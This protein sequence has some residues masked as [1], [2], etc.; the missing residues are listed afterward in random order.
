MRIEID[1]RRIYEKS[2]GIGRFS[3]NLIKALVNIDESN[4]YI[5]YKNLSIPR[6]LSENKNFTGKIIDIPRHTLK[7]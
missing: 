4:K 5:I 6:L 7:E 2:D 3:S 1:T